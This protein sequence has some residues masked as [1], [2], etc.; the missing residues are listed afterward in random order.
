MF[1]FNVGCSKQ[2]TILCLSLRCGSVALR[3]RNKPR[4]SRWLSCECYHQQ[5]VVEVWSTDFFLSFFHLHWTSHCIAPHRILRFLYE[6]NLY[7]LYMK[8]SQIQPREYSTEH[9]KR[10][11]FVKESCCSVFGSTRACKCHI[12]SCMPLN[13]SKY[14]ETT[15]EVAV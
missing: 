14:E 5:N 13:N 8:Q 1:F 11:P 7:D 4:E 6:K 3:Q 9:N 2:I 12:D 10:H 15:T